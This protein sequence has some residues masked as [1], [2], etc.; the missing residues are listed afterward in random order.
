V[1]ELPCFRTHAIEQLL[2]A[3]ACATLHLLS[4]S[5][6]EATGSLT[7]GLCDRLTPIS[8]DSSY[9]PSREGQS[10]GATESVCLPAGT[11]EA[12]SKLK[13]YILEWR[14]DFDTFDASKW[15]RAPDGW[16]DRYGDVD[17]WDPALVAVIDGTLRLAV[18]R[19]AGAWHAGLV[20]TRDRAS[21]T[22]GYI[23]IRAKLPAGQGLWSALWLMPALNRY[24]YWPRS[25]EIDMVEY[26]G[27]SDEA[28]AAYSSIHFDANGRGKADKRAR[29]AAG[30]E[31]SG[32]WHSWGCQ[33]DRSLDGR[34]FFRFFVDGKPFDSIDESE[35]REAPGGARGSPFD[36][37][38]HLILNL[39]IGGDWAGP[40]D[41]RV[42]GQ[43]LEIDWVK[44]YK[45]VSDSYGESPPPKT[46]NRIR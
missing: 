44:L 31:W 6:A 30:S 23:E 13:P 46:D 11:A 27:R 33:W 10:A 15:R 40:A 18:E 1:S 26:L 5:D 20:H 35:W 38:F 8:G 43:F 45:P 4:A 22:Y 16:T 37:P 21:W 39:A 3:I 7:D 41:D 42:S 19:K 17:V 14:D 24:G 9:M 36:Q 25:G 2:S 29:T 28:R 34:T 32:D 12:D